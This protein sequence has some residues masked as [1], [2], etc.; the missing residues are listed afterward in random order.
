MNPLLISPHPHFL[1][2]FATLLTLGIGSDGLQFPWKH[3]LHS[4]L[5]LPPAAFTHTVKPERSFT[6]M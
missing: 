1:F 6:L 3:Y 5:P 2:I 4:P